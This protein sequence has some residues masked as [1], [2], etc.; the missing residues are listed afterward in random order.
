M[1]TLS[2]RLGFVP[3]KLRSLTEA[4]DTISAPGRTMMMQMVGA[5][6]DFDEEVER[7]LEKLETEKQRCV[8]PGSPLVYVDVLDTWTANILDRNGKPNA[9]TTRKLVLEAAK[10]AGVTLPDNVGRRTFISMHVERYEN[11]PKTEKEANNSV[12]VIQERYLH[13]VSK[14]DAA[15]YWEI[16]P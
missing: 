8:N 9:V 7:E 12:E 6:T 15:K 5:F 2:G 1:G 10:K 14:A 13:L 11:L 4:I 16:R 3:T